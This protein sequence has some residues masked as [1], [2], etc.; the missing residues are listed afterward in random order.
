MSASAIGYCVH[1]VGVHS[2]LG[3]MG[4]DCF[5]PAILAAM[6]DAACANC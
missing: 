2:A 6:G 4:F 5:M 3:L 1:A